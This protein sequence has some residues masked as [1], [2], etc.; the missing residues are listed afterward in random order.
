MPSEGNISP[1]GWLNWFLIEF[2]LGKEKKKKNVAPSLFK[3]IV[4]CYLVSYNYG[5]FV[6]FFVFSSHLNAISRSFPPRQQTIL[7]VQRGCRW[8][9]S[10]CS[11]EWTCRSLAVCW[12]SAVGTPNCFWHGASLAGH[13]CL[14]WSVSAGLVY[15]SCY[16]GFG[17]YVSLSAYIQKHWDGVVAESGLVS[18]QLAP[19]TVSLFLI[20]KMPL[21]PN[22][23]PET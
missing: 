21:A 2:I 1:W 23:W 17:V 18:G 8:R 3:E 6:F 22:S 10:A 5:S 12:Q 9:L 19:V 15:Y 20:K 16:V 4:S 14:T 13:L 11:C 7:R